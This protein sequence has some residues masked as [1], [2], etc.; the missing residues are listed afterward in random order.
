MK[1]IL[2][3]AFA[4]TVFLLGL[5]SCGHKS[6]PATSGKTF[7]DDL[8]FAVTQLEDLHPNFYAKV[9][10]S[11]ILS[12]VEKIKSKGI[13]N[14]D[15]LI[16]SLNKVLAKIGDSHTTVD[17]PGFNTSAVRF[18]RD[19]DRLYISGVLPSDIKYLGGEVV[20]INGRKT[21]EV[22]FAVDSLVAAENESQKLNTSVKLISMPKVLNMLGIGFS[23]SKIYLKLKLKNL[24]KDY[25]VHTPT[26]SYDIIGTR[27]ESNPLWLS[28]SSSVLYWHKKLSND[29]VYVQYNSCSEMKDLSFKTFIEYLK[30]DSKKAKKLIVD[31]RRNSGGN[32]EIIN[33]LYEAIKKK[34]IQVEAILVLISRKT[35]SSALLNALELK[36][37]FGATL[38]GEPTGGA[39]SHFGEQKQLELPVSKL[40]ITYSTKHFKNNLINTDSLYPDE[41][42]SLT[43]EDRINGRD[44][45]LEK[46]LSL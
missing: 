14:K 24:I 27:A 23:D 44:P 10:K 29:V 7:E 33:P 21:N 6:I 41:N 20:S 17:W 38:V 26:T 13:K 2:V 9:K 19:A 15:E 43:I 36:M 11:D 31:L 8:N 5:V 32:S 18:A 3:G 40:Q 45:V 16:Y 46:A 42:V 22:L 35:F 39:P 25:T 28:K 4:L 12:E 30:V 34:E 1:K 37:D